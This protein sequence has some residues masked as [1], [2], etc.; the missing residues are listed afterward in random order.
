MLFFVGASL[1]L[2][3][4]VVGKKK[5]CFET[6]TLYNSLRVGIRFV[7]EASEHAFSLLYAHI[8]TKKVSEIKFRHLLYWCTTMSC[9]SCSQC[10]FYCGI[11]IVLLS[12]SLCMASSII[13]ITLAPSSAVTAMLVLPQMASLRLM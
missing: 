4:V 8:L 6:H 11:S 3:P 9:F 12:L 5:I 10:V 2:V 7:I 1:K 13:F